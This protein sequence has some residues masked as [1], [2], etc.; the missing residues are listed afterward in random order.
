MFSNPAN[1]YNSDD[2][3]FLI[4]DIQEFMIIRLA[5][6]INKRPIVDYPLKDYANRP[7]RSYTNS[8]DSVSSQALSYAPKI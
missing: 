4:E 7:P 2:A 5:T 8:Q 6:V 3:K 1:I